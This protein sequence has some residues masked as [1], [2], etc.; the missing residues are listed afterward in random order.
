MILKTKNMKLNY[1]FPTLS[2]LFFINGIFY[3][4][5]ENTRETNILGHWN[6]PDYS[7]QTIYVA[8]EG[9]DVELFINGISF[10]HGKQDLDSLYKFENV[11]FVPGD[12]NAVSYD[13]KGNELSRKTLRTAGTPAQLKLTVIENS[14]GFR[15]NGEDTAIIQFEVTDFQGNRCG[16][17][18]R[19]VN[20]EIDGPADWIDYEKIDYNEENSISKGKEIKA[21]NGTNTAFIR[22][23]ESAGEI[24]LTA[25]T[26]GLAPVEVTLCSTAVE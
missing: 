1:I 7:V 6:Y 23:T 4:K 16:N 11:I 8:S 3:I 14:E 26:K 25:K 21:H 24:K 5:G 12:L 10:G 20:F 9:E 13:G 19:I 22:S 17:D 18:D 2:F 15:A